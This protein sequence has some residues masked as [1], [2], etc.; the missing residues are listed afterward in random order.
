MSTPPPQ[1]AGNTG[2]EITATFFFLAFVLNF[3]KP[4]FTIDGNAVKSKWKTPTLFPVEPGQHSVQVHFPYLLLRTAGKAV[5]SASVKPG[6]VV[7]VTYK[8]PWILFLPGKIT[9]A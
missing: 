3:F 6:Q 2:I 4:V 9:T 7:K 8:A 5:T 1:S